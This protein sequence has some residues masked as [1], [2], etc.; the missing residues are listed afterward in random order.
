MRHE[1]KLLDESECFDVVRKVQNL[2]QYWTPRHEELPFY[3]LGQASYIDAVRD[4]EKYYRRAQVYNE[5]LQKN[6]GGLYE[7]LL[8]S[9]TTALNA[10]VAH[11][12]N[13]A[14]PGFHIFLAHKA[15]ESPMASIHMDLQYRALDWPLNE[16][17][18][19]YPLISFTLAI[20]LPKTGGGL[21]LWDI[22]HQEI[23]Q[24]SRNSNREFDKLSETEVLALL[25]QYEKSF[26]QYRVGTM[27]VHSGHQLHQI[28]PTQKM[29][30]CDKRVTLQ[31]HALLFDAAWH[32]Y[33]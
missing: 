20:E 26:C 10:P 15:F 8:T 1:I 22:Y 23:E 27:V 6:F 12:E 4:R 14:L 30:A 16:P 32:L 2:R 29:I 13:A 21:N 11:Y 9:L 17:I 28:A 19:S 25:S 31:G 7:K 3:T 24:L 33:W 5:I 18:D